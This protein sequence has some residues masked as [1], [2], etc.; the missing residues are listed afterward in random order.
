[1]KKLAL[2]GYLILY[3]F[4]YSSDTDYFILCTIYLL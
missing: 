3:N 2:S 1:M 4:M